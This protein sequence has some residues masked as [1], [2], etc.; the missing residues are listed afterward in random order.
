LPRSIPLKA[1][2]QA[3]SGIVN[4]R[5][6]WI[7]TYT[8]IAFP[9]WHPKVEHIAIEDIAHA[10]SNMCRFGGHTLVHYSVA[11]HSVI[12]AQIIHDLHGGVVRTR[13]ALLH[14]A[15]EAY[16]VDV[17]T[18]IKRSMPDYQTIERT[19]MLA[20]FDRFSVP[21][22]GLDDPKIHWADK[23]ALVTEYRDLMGHVCEKRW[24]KS[25]D[26]YP[27]LRDMISPLTPAMAE[28]EFLRAAKELGLS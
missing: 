19:I 17:P 26:V 8:G 18:P 7:Q 16:L 21:E 14:D 13:A 12:V 9:I 5:D 3:E 20:V 25:F 10:L 24:S 15:S 2:T 4:P 22:I 11:Q 1:E 23:V 27:P 6:E 28:S